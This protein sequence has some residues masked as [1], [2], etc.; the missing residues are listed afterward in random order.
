MKKYKAPE[1]SDTQRMD[2]L[3]DQGLF[4]QPNNIWNDVAWLKKKFP[5][6]GLS[7]RDSID[8][9]AHLKAF[10]ERSPKFADGRED[11][12]RYIHTFLPFNRRFKVALENWVIKGEATEFTYPEDNH[13]SE[14]WT[15]TDYLTFHH[16]GFLSASSIASKLKKILLAEGKEPQTML[17]EDTGRTVKVYPEDLLFQVIDPMRDEHPWSG[18]TPKHIS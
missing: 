11:M 13:A 17:W 4:T 16:C 12:R 5:T 18:L 10:I 8:L 1:L 6:E 15:I 14:L 2:I 9:D 7:L 3:S